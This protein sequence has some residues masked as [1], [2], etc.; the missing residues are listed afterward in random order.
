M[1]SPQPKRSKEMVEWF[2]GAMVA[3]L[4]VHRLDDTATH[5]AEKAKVRVASLYLYFPDK[6]S[7]LEALMEGASEKNLASTSRAWC[8]VGI[9]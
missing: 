1:L 7:L 8:A 6:E 4:T 5:M 9:R 3:N 2:Q